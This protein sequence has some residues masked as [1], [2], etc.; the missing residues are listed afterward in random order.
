MKALFVC[1]CVTAV[2]S[3]SAQ[4]N[5]HFE[6]SVGAGFTVPVVNT[7]H[8]LDYGWNVAAG[9]GYYWHHVGAMIDVNYTSMGINS[10]TLAALGAPSGRFRILSAT[11]NPIVHLT[12]KSPVDVYA[13][14]GGGFYHQEQDVTEATLPLSGSTA[15][16]FPGVVSTELKQSASTNKPGLDAGVGIAFGSMW[17]GRFF[18]EAR[19]NRIFLNS[20]FRT[21]YVPV[22]F[23]FRW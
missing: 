15:V 12:P 6:A 19:Y 21:V 23:G 2:A 13:T 9:G 3:L 5:A 7:G 16:L 4:E 8:A 11:L 18:A 1:I 10:T 14:A 17:K 20:H 22:T